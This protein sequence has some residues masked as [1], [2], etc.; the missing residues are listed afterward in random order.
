MALTA[1]TEQVIFIMMDKLFQANLSMSSYHNAMIN[2]QYGR[3]IYN[4]MYN[5]LNQAIKWCDAFSL[6]T[7]K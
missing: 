1:T 2:L 6:L 3:N 7:I 4:Y 5:E